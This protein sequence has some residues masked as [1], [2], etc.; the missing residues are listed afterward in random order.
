MANGKNNGYWKGY[1]FGLLTPFVLGIGL[2]II[3][4]IAVAIGGK[5]GQIEG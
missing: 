2:T 4:S 3:A 5:R 1:V